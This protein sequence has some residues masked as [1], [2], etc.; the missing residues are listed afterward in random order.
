MV[1]EQTI[2]ELIDNIAIDRACDFADH[3]EEN[4]GNYGNDNQSLATG[5]REGFVEGYIFAFENIR[6][7]WREVSNIDGI[8]LYIDKLKPL[9]ER[10]PEK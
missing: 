6:D 7:L 8:E 9:L 4:S 1:S 10:Y 2:D 3:Y 5:Y